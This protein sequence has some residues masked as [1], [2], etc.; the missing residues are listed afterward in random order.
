MKTHKS[1]SKL[2]VS[3]KPNI[4]FG[5]YE[6]RLID[7]K[8]IR[9]IINEEQNPLEI[10]SKIYF[11]C[12]RTKT[13]TDEYKT[14]TWLEPWQ[15]LER[16]DYNEFDLSL[17]LCYTI[18]IT[19]HFKAK[20]IVIHNCIIKESESNNRKFSYI[21]EFNNQFLNVN[22]MVIMTKEQF[23]KRYVLHY[24]HNIKNKINIDLI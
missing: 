6:Q 18:M 14:D 10:L 20:V 22:D 17:L 7:W 24:T 13:K 11:Y 3:H 21:I 15:L 23:D 4:F 9:S 12:P 1:Y 16:N 8:N 19:E 2:E 5:T